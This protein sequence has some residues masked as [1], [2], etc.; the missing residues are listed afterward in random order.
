[1]KLTRAQRDSLRLQLIESASTR[2]KD[3][4]NFYSKHLVQTEDGCSVKAPDMPDVITVLLR[5]RLK[6]FDSSV[7]FFVLAGKNPYGPKTCGNALCFDP[8]HA[9]E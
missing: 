1:M 7:V 4:E 2:P 9:V 6:T 5:R 8:S 3:I